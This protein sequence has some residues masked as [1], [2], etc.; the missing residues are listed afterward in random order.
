MKNILKNLKNYKKL[1]P[2]T[3]SNTVL[4]P[5]LTNQQEKQKEREE[6]NIRSKHAISNLGI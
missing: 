1:N 6:K 3:I 2:N 5:E 4:I